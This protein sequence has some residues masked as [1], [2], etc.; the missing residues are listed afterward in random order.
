MTSVSVIVPTYNSGRFLG[1]AID[2]IL[3]QTVVPDQ[4]IVV[5]DGSTDDTEQ[6]M[7]RYPQVE[8]IRQANGGVSSARNA[9]LD[10]ARGDFVTFL[11][12][13]DRW[14]PEFV[15][16]ML[17]C[18]SDDPSIV[19]AFCNFVRFEHPSGRVLSDQFRYYPEL[20][21]PGPGSR[22]RISPVDAFSR[23]VSMSD[24]PAFT[25]MMMVNRALLGTLRFDRRLAICEDLHWTLQLAMRGA[26]TY[27]D[28]ILADVRRH[29]HNAS[30][31]VGSMAVHK[32]TAL[33]ALQPYVNFADNQRPYHDRLVKAHI[34]AALYL[35]KSGLRDYRDCL[36][37]PG[38][39]RRKLKGLVRIVMAPLV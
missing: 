14:R 4:I 16:R 32:L 20:V 1:E 30:R 6:V 11:D 18:V 24:I 7:A 23:L 15:E 10:A 12:A 36:R 21:R 9:G 13:D 26:V 19:F 31:D 22:V 17:S 33:K 38:S 2:S 39:K 37:V 27:T 5:D 34:D 29:E 3:A 28:D 35:L 25:P 8:Y